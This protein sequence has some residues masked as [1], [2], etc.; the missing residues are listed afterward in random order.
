MG[1]LG[2]LGSVAVAYT[3]PVT[4]LEARIWLIKRLADL[5]I[6]SPEVEADLLLG[7]L[8]SMT[9]SDLFMTR[10]RRLTVEQERTL[11]VWLE[12]RASREPLQHILGVA[13]FYGLELSVTEDVLIPRPETEKLVELA[14]E[15]LQDVNTPKLLDVGTGSGAIALAL[16]LE[17][18]DALVM[19]SDVST[20][21]LKIA[22]ANAARHGPEVRFVMSDLLGAPEVKVFAKTVDLLAANLPYLPEADRA[23]VSAEVRRDPELA[24]YSG[25]DGLEHFRR[26]ER[27]AHSLL[28]KGAVGLFELDPRNVLRAQREASGWTASKVLP[29]LVGR[30]RFLRLER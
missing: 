6:A 20:A 28:K 24:L 1:T 18:P 4:V 2:G 23:W 7:A 9:R 15:T 3:E 29:D 22:A 25:H 11:A 14:L 10:Q 13:H 26:L 30:E 16:K 21:A 17:R 5:G 8:L 27:Q 19:A 12:R